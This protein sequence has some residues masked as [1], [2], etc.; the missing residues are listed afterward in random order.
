MEK[1]SGLK[2]NENFFCGYSP[3]RINPGDKQRDLSEIVKVTSGSNL[4]ASLLVDQ[5][6]KEIVFAGT[7]RVSTIKV[8]EAAKIIEN[9]Q[10]DINIALINELCIIFEKMGLDTEEVL[11]A[12]ETK[13]NFLKF[14]PG[15]V[16][17]HCIGVDPY[18]LTYK[19]EK[20]GHTPKM[21]LA[22]REVNE[23][24]ASY[25]VNQLKRKMDASDI[26]ILSSRIL[27]LGLAFK[28]NCPDV[29]NSKVFDINNELVAMGCKV[30]V[31]DPMVNADEVSNLSD[32]NLIKNI[33]TG[34]YDATLICVAH[35][36]FKDIGISKK[37][38]EK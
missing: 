27:I 1:T 36:V 19:A 35:D 22:G 13:W 32:L 3:E 37:I 28:E 20:I 18:Y 14:R 21:I 2:Y 33:E 25:V 9:T 31:F 29:R 15:L 17:G 5:L 4:K 24:M 30:D 26:N 6:Y 11:E 34:S 8:A 10:R 16:G 23:S 12:A 7:H 38:L